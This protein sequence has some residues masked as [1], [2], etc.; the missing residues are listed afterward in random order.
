MELEKLKSRKTK[1]I[2]PTDLVIDKKEAMMGGEE[3]LKTVLQSL[4][5]TQN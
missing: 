2:K 4:V 1:G 3:E 5:W